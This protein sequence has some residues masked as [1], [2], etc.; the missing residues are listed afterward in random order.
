LCPVAPIC[1]KNNIGIYVCI[2]VRKKNIQGFYKGGYS[3]WY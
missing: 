1:I 2:V 3:Q